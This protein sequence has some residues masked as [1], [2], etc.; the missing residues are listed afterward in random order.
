ML[1]SDRFPRNG[2]RGTVPT[3]RDPGHRVGGWGIFAFARG[4]RGAVKCPFPWAVSLIATD[5]GRNARRTTLPPKFQP[6][7][8]AG[9]PV[10]APQNPSRCPIKSRS[11]PF[12]DVLSLAGLFCANE[13]LP[14]LASVR[15]QKWAKL[16]VTSRIGPWQKNR[17][18]VRICRVLAVFVGVLNRPYK[19]GVAGSKPALPVRVSLLSKRRTGKTPSS[20]A[21]RGPLDFPPS[22]MRPCRGLGLR[23]AGA[24][25]LHLAYGGILEA[26][27]EVRAKT[28]RHFWHCHPYPVP[29]II[30][31]PSRP[32]ARTPPIFTRTC[33]VNWR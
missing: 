8:G 17:G 16:A 18:L 32:T 23:T 3:A 2:Y 22:G 13:T 10:S 30:P 26:Y 25:L 28:Y 19:P 4:S 27:A 7:P 33:N 12:S 9:S 21:A 15:S 1:R 6:Q 31:W 14:L 20:K 29:R 5:S 11:A 24:A